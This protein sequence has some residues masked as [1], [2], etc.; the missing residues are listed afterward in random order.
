MTKEQL[1]CFCEDVYDVLVGNTY[2][3]TPEQFRDKYVFDNE[4]EVDYCNNIINIG[5]FTLTI[6]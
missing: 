3:I 2:H 1:S 4:T 6:E 5:P